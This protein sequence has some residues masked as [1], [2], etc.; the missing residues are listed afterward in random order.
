MK[1]ILILDTGNEWGG[2]TNSLFEYLKR[3]DRDQ[4]HFTALFYKN[5]KKSGSSDLKTEFQKL[6]IDF[7]LIPQAP[8]TFFLKSLK[9]AVRMLFFYNKKLLK[10]V[11]FFLEYHLK[12]NKKAGKI[13]EILIT[14]K[15]DLLYM[16]NQPSSNLEGILASR[17]TGIPA[18]QH[19][20]IESELNKTETTLA[21]THLKK[22]MTVSEGVKNSLVRQ[23]IDANKC[24]V[25]YNGIDAAAQPEKDLRFIRKELGAE[26]NTVLIGTVCSLI[27]RK[28]VKDLLDAF[29]SVLKTATQ[30]IKCVIVGEGPEGETLQRYAEKLNIS[31]HT[32]FTGFK[33][34]AVSYINAFDIFIL[35]SRKEGLP[36]VIL[37]AMLMGK[38]VVASDVTGPAELVLSG[39]TGYLVGLGQTKEFAG[40]ITALVRDSGLRAKMG[41]AARQRVVEKFDINSYVKGIEKTFSEALKK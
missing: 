34:D 2:G 24:I 15:S 5:Y 9:E 28:R 10:R 36:R 14:S 19:C 21:N 37:E 8:N 27:K 32:I 12:I 25:V 35:T 20:R 23:G 1:R 39:S 40:A 26:E 29:A 11:I 18:V 17:N 16:N 7:I 38:P 41:G 6:G 22:I 4:Y 33:S 3:A 13:A 30:P 31:E